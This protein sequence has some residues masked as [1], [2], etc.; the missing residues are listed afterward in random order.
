MVEGKKKGGGE[1]NNK[2]ARV[3]N[4]EP[5]IIYGRGEGGFR[6]GSHCFQGGREGGS[7]VAD[8]VK[9]AGLERIDCQFTTNEKRGGRGGGKESQEYYR[10]L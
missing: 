9:R 8:R 5:V 3:L 7:V 4:E 2:E 6:G 10:A 1:A